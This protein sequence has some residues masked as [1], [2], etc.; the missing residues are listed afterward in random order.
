MKELQHTKEW[1]DFIKNIMMKKS[2]T[3]CG[4]NTRDVNEKLFILSFQQK[5]SLK[6]L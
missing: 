6:L 2:A 5:N 4:T 3:T 1:F